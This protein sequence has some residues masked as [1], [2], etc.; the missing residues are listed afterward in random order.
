MLGAFGLSAVSAPGAGA[1]PSGTAPLAGSA[2]PALGQ[3]RSLGPVAAGAAVDFE[4][5]LN[6]RDLAGAQALA[7][8]TATPGSAS[9]RKFLTPAA[10]ESQFSPTRRQVAAVTAWVRSQGLK[11]RSIAADR[12]A[13]EVTGTSG[14]V[15]QAFDTTLGY[16]AVDGQRLRVSERDLSVPSSLAGIVAGALGVNEIPSTPSNVVAARTRRAA[17]ART[18]SPRAI[19]PPPAQTSPAPCGHFYGQAFDTTS[20]PYGTGYFEPLPYVPCGYTPSQIRAVYGVQGLVNLGDNGTGQTVAII[21]AY[22]SPTLLA[23]AQ[24][25]AQT[26]DPGHPLASSQFSE[27][28]AHSF[29]DK[30]AC[31]ASGWFGE[32]SLD[33][34]A[35]HAMAP[36]ANIVYAGARNCFRGLYDMLRTVVDRHLADVVTNSWGDNGGDL[37]DDAG[38]RSAVDDTLIMAAGTGVTVLFAS[39]DNGDEFSTLAV[40][41]PDYPASSPWVT[42]V[43]GTTLEIGFG[44]GEY[45]WSTAT[46][47]LCTSL[48][49][50]LSGCSSSTLNSWLP[51]A[52]DGGSGGGTSFHYRQPAYQ[53]G[54]VPLGVA[55]RNA[56]VTGSAP[57]RVEP[58]VAMDGDPGTGLLVGL[59]QSFPGGHR[60][61]QYRVGGTSLSSPL[62]AGVVALADQYGGR[63]L[64]FLNPALYAVAKST[65][66]VL[67]DVAPGP[68]EAQSRVDDANSVNASG[69]L[70]F[71][72][73]IVDY[74]GPETF[75]SDTGS[76]VS[77]DVSVSPTKG[78]DDMTGLGAP[79]LGFVP[80]LARL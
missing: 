70:L 17:T 20:P 54:V 10:W 80:T 58:D 48:L 52:F 7:L 16:R 31:D 4:L 79:R 71:T 15:E 61:G 19:R 13:I 33:V 23:D 40:N 47:A 72:T 8:A 18:V 29:N 34:E 12:L 3:G 75:C 36:G 21:D 1:Q 41:A 35:V 49:L 5:V 68:R 22:A 55:R 32:Q 77:Q 74:Q 6:P 46:S 50:G 38:T 78:Y 67:D 56:A 14:G 57:M 59:T 24:R 64:G 28:L 43:G 11:V 51:A 27:R 25:Y 60:Y 63:A 65:P 69:G 73:R 42:A 53:V 44:I 39:G 62:F 9:Y 30:A 37:L 76:C 66:Q 2:S 45:G 26:E